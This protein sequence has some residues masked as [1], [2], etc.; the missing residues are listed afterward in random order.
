MGIAFAY[1]DTSPQMGVSKPGFCPVQGRLCAAEGGRSQGAA[2]RIS[3]IS[4]KTTIGNKLYR[5]FGIILAMVLVLFIVNFVA[6]R[7]E[8]SAKASSTQAMDLKGATGQVRFQIMQNQLFL[9][10]YLLS[11]DTREIEKMNDG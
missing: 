7:R 9:T 11:G 3:D 4:N 1:A 6:V 10:N 8:Q 5:S 2:M